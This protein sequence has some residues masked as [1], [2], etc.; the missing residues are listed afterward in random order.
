MDLQP[1]L[2]QE[3]I[4]SCIEESSNVTGTER[5]RGFLFIV[6]SLLGR[7]SDC[8]LHSRSLFWLVDLHHMKVLDSVSFSKDAVGLYFFRRRLY[9]ERAEFKFHLLPYTPTEMNILT[10]RARSTPAFSSFDDCIKTRNNV[11]ALATI[12]F[13]QVECYGFIIVPPASAARRIAI[14]QR[15]CTLSSSLTHS[16]TFHCVLEF[17]AV[18][19]CRRGG[20]VSNL[21]F[22]VCSGAQVD[23][24]AAYSTKDLG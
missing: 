17:T 19:R 5:C 22:R 24:I 10:N 2:P 20:L 18:H 8:Y 13:G 3:E 1:P 12:D 11:G 7:Q 6:K 14:K 4:R 23:N 15:K 9:V 16:K 21:G